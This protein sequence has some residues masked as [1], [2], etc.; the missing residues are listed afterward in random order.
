[1]KRAVVT[2]VDDTTA[3]IGGEW[4]VYSG[5][6]VRECTQEAGGDGAAYSYITTQAAAPGDP[7]AH[8]DA[9]EELWNDQGI[10]TERYQ[11]GG[12][13]PI[14]GIRGSGGPTTSIDFLAD[15]RGYSVDALSPCADG[16]PVELKK[17]GE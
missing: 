13:D 12:D 16:D 17:Q 2:V 14:L 8:I 7:T 11:S 4:D 15:E 9:V 3:A 5:P 6:A 1:V 10:T